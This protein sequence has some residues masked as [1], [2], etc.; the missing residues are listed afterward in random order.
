M[1]SELNEKEMLGVIEKIR[2]SVEFFSNF[3]PYELV[4]MLKVSTTKKIKPGEVIFR[5]GEQGQEMYII[6]YGS[7]SIYKGEKELA[8]LGTNNYFG[9]MGIIQ[10]DAPRTA[11]AKAL[12]D[13]LLMIVNENILSS[14]NITLKLK[15]YK[16]FC[17]MLAQRLRVTNEEL[18]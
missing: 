16:N 3:E 7:V 12:T 9:E 11:S 18:T 15:L 8:E 1:M 5:E 4:D 2:K 6:V 10:H 13:T 14:T 17:Q